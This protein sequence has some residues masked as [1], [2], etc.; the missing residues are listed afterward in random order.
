MQSNNTRE[1]KFNLYYKLLG[2]LIKKGKKS[3]SK[4]LLDLAFFKAGLYFNK[5]FFYLLNKLFVSLNVFVETKM[6]R[7]K[8]SRYLV[9]FPISLRRR[10]Y[11]I[12]K[13]IV[14]TAKVNNKKKCSFSEKLFDE[15]FL[16]FKTSKSKVL[17]LKKSNIS[18]ALA[19]RSNAH[20]RW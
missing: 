3:K 12:V 7:V 14:L 2:F 17:E 10:V 1:K 13:W 8:R 19:N 5:P 11:L 9:P 16:I 6:I 4:Y 18:K 20:Y 15:I